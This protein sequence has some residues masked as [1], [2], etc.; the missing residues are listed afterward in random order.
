MSDASNQKPKIEYPCQWG[1]KVIGTEEKVVRVA[2]ED[3][4]KT[5]LAGFEGNNSEDRPVVLG[6][7]RSSGGGKY[8]SVGLEL[9][10][11]SEEE[12]NTIFRALA[13]RPEIKMVL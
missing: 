5:C 10:V 11:R 7:S 3:C 1:F 4:I 6:N 9:Q 8:V 2:I 12:R 13:D